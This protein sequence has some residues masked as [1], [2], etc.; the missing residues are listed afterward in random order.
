MI[1]RLDAAAAAAALLEG[2]LVALPTDTV[3]GVGAS[4]A[5]S[6]SVRALFALK[7]RPVG[8]P[9]PV[10]AA[11]TREAEALTSAWPD[12]AARLAAAFW[13]GALTLAVPGAG[14]LAALV[15]SETGRVGLR[16]PDHDVLRAVLELAGP[17][18]LT[19]ANRHRE[20]PCATAE[21]VDA[22]FA[23]GAL[24]G[25][26][27]GGRCDGAVSSVVEVDGGWRLVREGAIPEAA[28]VAALAS[29]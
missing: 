2:E 19:S 20:P 4:I 1:A 8:V 5:N 6:D 27:D 11:T 23:G 10:V 14:E 26:V 29:R 25:V 17:I 7:G 21:E 3:Y 28:L 12:E 24:G 9:L 15:G 22:A 16:V 18:A 13:P